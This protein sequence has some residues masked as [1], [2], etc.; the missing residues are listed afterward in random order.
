MMLS[1]L[2]ST[3][4]DDK[5][6]EGDGMGVAVCVW[7]SSGDGLI[8]GRGGGSVGGVKAEVRLR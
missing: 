1:A 6:D 5:Q 4:Y 8:G 2:W 3:V 7:W